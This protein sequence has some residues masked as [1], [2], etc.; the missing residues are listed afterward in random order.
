MLNLDFR[1]KI[2]IKILYIELVGLR[3]IHHLYLP[4]STILSDVQSI[5]RNNVFRFS[6]TASFVFYRHSKCYFCFIL[7]PLNKVANERFKYFSLQNTQTPIFMDPST[8]WKMEFISLNIYK[9]YIPMNRLNQIIYLMFCI[10]SLF[11]MIFL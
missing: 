3:Y 6:I 1:S 11:F 7:F 9:L 4:H 8:K 5:N 10:F 2:D